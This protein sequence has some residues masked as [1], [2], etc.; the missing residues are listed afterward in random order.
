[1]MTRLRFTTLLFVGTLLLPGG[2]GFC[3]SEFA[4]RQECIDNANT[5]IT[6]GGIPC[7]ECV[8]KVY[9]EIGGTFCLSAQER[10]CDAIGECDCDPCGKEVGDLYECALAEA[11]CPGAECSASTVVKASF[12]TV[13]L[14]AVS[15]FF[16]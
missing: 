10:V 16:A 5:T 7:L 12:L 6:G 4:A 13:V 1:M 9:G 14:A 11:S 15:L 3:E 8:D 2:F